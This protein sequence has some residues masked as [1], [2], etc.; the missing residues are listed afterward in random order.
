MNKVILKS[1]N[2]AVCFYILA[3]ATFTQLISPAKI[4]YTYVTASGFTF[5]I[6][7]PLY[8]ILMIFAIYQWTERVN[9][10]IVDGISYNFIIIGILYGS[11]YIFM[12]FQ[13]Y[14]VQ[15]IIHIAFTIALILTY[16][17]LEYYYPPAG[18]FDN[19]FIH[20]LFSIWT[21][22]GLYATILGIWVAIPALNTITLTIIALIILISIG[23][24]VV[25]YYPTIISFFIIDYFPNSDFIFSAVIVWCLIGVACNQVEVLPI[26]VV[27]AAG[28][29]LISGAIL[30]SIA[31]FF[32]EHRNGIYISG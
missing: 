3:A 25:D 11:V 23:W 1:L 6:V 28:I 8:F 12:M 31:T 2:A 30:K 5:G 32:S 9:D 15:A 21:A 22:W 18:I 16:Y 17:K 20:K 26:L 4:P 14:L 29:G 10:T 24:F 7:F 27:T 19:L 13:F